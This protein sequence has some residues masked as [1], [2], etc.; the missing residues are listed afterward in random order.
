M[1][2]KLHDFT[3]RLQEAGFPNDVTSTKDLLVGQVTSVTCAYLNGALIEMLVSQEEE[4]CELKEHILG[5]AKHGEQLL[6]DIRQSSQSQFL[7]DTQQNN[8]Q[9]CPDRISNVSAVER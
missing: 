3:Q 1:S 6:A 7:S 5:A 8:Y 4:Y 2:A 9:N